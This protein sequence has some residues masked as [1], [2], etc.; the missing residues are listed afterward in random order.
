MFAD[1]S[2]INIVYYILAIIIALSIHEAMH[3]FTAHW[4]GDTT[5][6]DAGRLTLNPLKHIDP[7]TTVLLPIV[8]LLVFHV[9]LL[10][11]RPVPFNPARVKYEEFGGALIAL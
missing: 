7:Y 2:G 11:A 5:A 9:P 8:T 3:G 4:L 6:Q 1:L 10:A